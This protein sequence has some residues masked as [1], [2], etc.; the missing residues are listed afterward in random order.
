MNHFKYFTICLN[1]ILVV[2]FASC[3]KDSESPPDLRLEGSLTY[4]GRPLGFKNTEVTLDLYQPGYAI[5]TA[6]PC[7]VN[8]DGGY[9]AQ[10]FPGSYKM[11][12]RRNVAP[13]YDITDSISI[14][15]TG[16]TSK[17]FE[18]TPFFYVNEPAFTLKGDSLF[19]TVNIEKIATDR[20]LEKVGLYISS[21]HYCDAIYSTGGKAEVAAGDISN[22]TNVTLKAKL[23]PALMQQKYLFARVG[24]KTIGLNAQ[25][26]SLVKQVD[27]K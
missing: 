14:S 26:Y 10:L 9:A 15:V 11:T 17:S 5:L 4:K 21:S 22:L 8:Q 16:N 12:F 19:A 24:A 20:N 7:R 2:A 13:F 3:K 25:N 6:I 23:T 18:V 1:I 27:I